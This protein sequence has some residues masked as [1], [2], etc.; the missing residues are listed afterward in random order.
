MNA[1]VV[2]VQDFRKVYGEVVAVDGISFCV[3]CGEIFGL[4]GPNG[5]GKTST[6]ESLEGLRSPDGGSLRIL[7]V[8]PAR[9]PANSATL[10]ACNSRPLA[11][12]RI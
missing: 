3:R 12:R 8:D 11:F 5:A 7:G 6:L 9:N 4:L 2:V 10:S 1:D